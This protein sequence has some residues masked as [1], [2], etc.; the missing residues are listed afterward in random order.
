MRIN[1]YLIFLLSL[2]LY[3]CAYEKI[4]KNSMYDLDE[5]DACYLD[6]KSSLDENKQKYLDILIKLRNYNCSRY[7][8]L[9]VRGTIIQGY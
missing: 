1:K 5:F 2:T 6:H 8:E 4:V 3:S 7:Y 9:F